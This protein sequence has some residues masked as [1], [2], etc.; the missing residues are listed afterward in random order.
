MLEGASHQAISNQ[1]CRASLCGANQNC[2]CAETAGGDKR[3]VQIR[4]LRCPD[5]DRYDRGDC[6]P[7]KV[8]VKIGAAVATGGATSAPIYAETVRAPLSKAEQI[9]SWLLRVPQDSYFRF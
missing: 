8:C 2:V 4:D 7:S 1:R 9:K 3:C 5:R 6:G